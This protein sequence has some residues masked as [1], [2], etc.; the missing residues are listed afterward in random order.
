MLLALL[1]GERPE[2][3]CIMPT[4]MVVRESA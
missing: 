3:Q 1:R 2:P 4:R